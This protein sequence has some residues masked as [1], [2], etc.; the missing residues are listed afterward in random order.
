MFSQTGQ[1]YVLRVSI[2]RTQKQTDGRQGKSEFIKENK[3]TNERRSQGGKLSRGQWTTKGA[4]TKGNMIRKNK[5][6]KAL[7]QN[8]EEQS[9][10]ELTERKDVV[11]SGSNHKIFQEKLAANNPKTEQNQLGSLAKEQ[12]DSRLKLE[13]SL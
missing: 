8:G 1:S 12:S 10:K 5:Q 11:W 13:E 4:R 9:K 2:L 6:Q 3:K 7:T